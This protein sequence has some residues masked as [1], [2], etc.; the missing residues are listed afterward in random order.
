[1]LAPTREEGKMPENDRTAPEDASRN[2]EPYG[3]YETQ[4]RQHN[5]LQGN[6]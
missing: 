3:S 1:M 5:S 4:D 6:K 2:V